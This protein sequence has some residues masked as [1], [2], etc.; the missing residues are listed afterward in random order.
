MEY[1]NSIPLFVLSYHV[2]PNTLFSNE[3]IDILFGCSPI[4][5]LKLN[6][7]VKLLVCMSYLN[8]NPYEIATSDIS[9]P[10]SPIPYI[11]LSD[12]IKKLVDGPAYTM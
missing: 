6:K 10:K 8:K 4:E 9:L 5:F 7:L 3:L 12:V 11:L 1:L 2:V